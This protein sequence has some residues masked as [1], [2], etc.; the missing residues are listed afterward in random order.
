MKG[1]RVRERAGKQTHKR[2]KCE[3]GEKGVT[4]S[5][6]EAVRG[7]VWREGDKAREQI[8]VTHQDGRLSVHNL[9]AV[10][11]HGES[12]VVLLGRRLGVRLR[13]RY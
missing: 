12:D 2:R 10:V 3:G 6:R 5:Q 9:R 4:E 7:Y 13:P 11:H 1:R 8:K